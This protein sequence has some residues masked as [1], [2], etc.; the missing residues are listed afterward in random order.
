MKY[1]ICTFKMKKK[2][3]EVLATWKKY[4]AP[5]FRGHYR[6]IHSFDGMIKLIIINLQWS[7][8]QDSSVSQQIIIFQNYMSP[9]AGNLASNKLVFVTTITELV[10]SIVRKKLML[11]H[12]SSNSQKSE[13][14]N[15]KLSE[16]NSSVADSEI[17]SILIK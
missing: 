11:F 14:V 9:M 8:S 13:N 2:C 1:I 7:L 6:R 3:V 4:I 5:S 10:S 12:Y 16:A 15:S 17:Y